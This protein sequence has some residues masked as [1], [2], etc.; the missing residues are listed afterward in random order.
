MAIGRNSITAFGEQDAK[1][2][3]AASMTKLLATSN[4]LENNVETSQ[5]NALISNR[6]TEDNYVTSFGPGGDIGVEVSKETIPAIIKHTIGSE[7]LDPV[8][9]GVGSGPYKHK[10]QPA[11]TIEG[12]LTFLKYLKDA[13]YHELYKDCKVNQMTF[14]LTSKAVITYALS[15]LSILAESKLGVPTVTPAD[16]VG[17]KLFA[18]DTKA[19]NWNGADIFSLINELNFTHNNNIDGDD[20]GLSRERRS[21]EVQG[22]EHTVNFTTKFDAAQ[23][24]SLKD[25]LVKNNIIP[26]K[27]NIGEV[28]GETDPYLA[29]DYPKLKLTQVQA[30]IGGPDRVTVNIQGIAL[31]DNVQGYNVAVE[32]V[33][34]QATKY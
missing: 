30:N 13:G 11:Q 12:W 29:I 1:G 16:N 2:T 7:P 23:Y 18:W 19:V 22:S 17:G 24:F 20:Y 28:S 3:P 27:I 25:D 14:N 10:F 32:I 34:N 21:L 15:I 6:F 33:D 5:S 4:S 26:V 31:W 9:L 8:D